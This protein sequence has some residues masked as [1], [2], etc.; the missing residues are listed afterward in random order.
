MIDIHTHI[1]PDVDDG[2]QSIEDSITL[3]EKAAAE[4]IHT[5]A[6]TPA[7]REGLNLYSKKEII[8]QV[9]DVNKHLQRRSINITVLPGQV[10]S[11]HGDL[12]DDLKHNQLMTINEDTPY[13][14]LELPKDHV[15]QYIS[16]LL[17]QLQMEGYIPIIAQPEHNEQVQHNPNVLYSL[18]KNGAKAQLASGSLCGKY[19]KKIKKLSH[20]LIE[21]NLVHLI[22][23]DMKLE[24]KRKFYM[25]EAF[26]LIKKSYGPDMEEQLAYN[27]RLVI[28]GEPIVGDLPEHIKKR[29]F[30]SIL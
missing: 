6:A 18:I 21:A 9:Q 2:I 16:T 12:L 28:E 14:L 5:L 24:K 7:Y 20:Q 19:G 26:Q 13:L 3:A 17:F 8:T 25:K 30:I 1:L 23:S 29:K 10:I 22:A 11:I 15:P 4:G 27:A